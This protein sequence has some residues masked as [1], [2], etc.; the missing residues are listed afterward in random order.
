VSAHEAS[1]VA[2]KAVIN[3]DNGYKS[4]LN[5]KIDD[6]GRI[7]I[8][9]DKS[10]IR[11][12]S[13]LTKLWVKVS[14]FYENK[15][16]MYYLTA[17]DDWVVNQVNTIKNDYTDGSVNDEPNTFRPV[18]SGQSPEL[19]SKRIEVH[20]VNPEELPSKRKVTGG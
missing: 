2:K 13:I 17:P 8:S 9:L 15:M 12:K 20:Q 6:E 10:E 18:L 14:N 4:S 19:N 11:D 16:D 1:R 5:F 3:F 7:L